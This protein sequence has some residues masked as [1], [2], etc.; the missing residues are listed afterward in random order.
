MIIFILLIIVFFGLPILSNNI[1]LPRNFSSSELG[2]FIGSI[3]RYWL[4][5]FVHA[6]Q[7]LGL[8]SRY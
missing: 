2:D 8:L 1:K 4:D 6:L 7:K 5:L 3:L